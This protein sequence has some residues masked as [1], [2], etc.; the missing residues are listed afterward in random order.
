M[1][2]SSSMAFANIYDLQNNL[3]SFSPDNAH[4]SLLGFS[5]NNVLAHENSMISFPVGELNQRGMQLEVISDN[6]AVSGVLSQNELLVYINEVD[7]DIAVTVRVVNVANV[8]ETSLSFTINVVNKPTLAID[9]FGT[10]QFASNNIADVIVGD[11]QRFLSG[12]SGGSFTGNF[13]HSLV[14]VSNAPLVDMGAF[15]NSAPNVH[16]TSFGVPIGQSTPMF[17]QTSKIAPSFA[18]VKAISTSFTQTQNTSFVPSALIALGQEKAKE[19]AKRSAELIVNN[20]ASSPQQTEESPSIDQPTKNEV[21]VGNDEKSPQQAQDDLLVFNPVNNEQPAAVK[22]PEP[23]SFV[24]M[25]LA[26]I[27]GVSVWRFKKRS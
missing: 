26:L 21:E 8:M 18:S 17:Y 20:N 24:L 27:T 4:F 25:L 15:K 10:T 2:T 22:I 14:K 6:N 7:E 19:I 12:F 11:T 23:N 9:N 1:L 16:Q 13:G 3:A 5:N